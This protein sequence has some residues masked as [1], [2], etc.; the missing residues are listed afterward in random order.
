MRSGSVLLMALIAAAC[1]DASS[2]LPDPLDMDGE[3]ER[4][5]APQAGGSTSDFGGDTVPCPCTASGHFVRV[6]VLAREEDSVTLRVEELLGSAPDLPLVPGDAIE[7]RFVGRLPCYRGTTEVAPGDEAL[8]VLRPQQMVTRE[9]WAE[10]RLTPW[11][12]DLLFA[13]TDEAE[14]FVPASDVAHLMDHGLEECRSTYGDWSELPG[15]ASDG[16]SDVYYC[17]HD[18]EAL[19]CADIE[20]DDV[21]DAAA[22]D[23]EQSETGPS[24]TSVCRAIDAACGTSDE[25]CADECEAAQAR[26][27]SCGESEQWV[28]LL[29]C[30]A[31][32]HF[33]TGC[34]G[35]FNLCARACSDAGPSVTDRCSP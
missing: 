4:P 13:Q 14:L 35:S 24:C 1:Q 12:S 33:D 19:P 26:A 9:R 3:P 23:A 10:V 20:P 6:V 22:Q 16:E 8:A 30:C 7:A 31:E 25:V 21:R 17:V 32:Q 15:T 27:A 28:Q 29:A 34:D 5:G 11:A 18:G 2:T